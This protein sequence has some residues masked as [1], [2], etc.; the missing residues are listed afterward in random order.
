MVWIW[1]SHK[2]LW[3]RSSVPSGSTILE[4]SGRNLKSAVLMEEVSQSPESAYEGYL[5][6][7]P[8]LSLVALQSSCHHDVLLHHRL[9]VME[10]PWAKTSEIRSQSNPPF[11]SGYSGHVLCQ[12]TRRPD[13]SSSFLFWV[14]CRSQESTTM[15]L[16]S[17]CLCLCL[18]LPSFLSTY[19]LIHPSIYF[20]AHI[21]IMYSR[22]IW[23]LQCKPDWPPAAPV[24]WVLV[25]KGV[26]I[27]ATKILKY[28]KNI[29]LIHMCKY[30]SIKKIWRDTLKI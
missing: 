1:V 3:F 16:S 20:Q 30:M 21:L 27:P 12:G 7:G 18:S 5:V 28:W 11:P 13:N 9:K 25:I 4:T 26:T 29:Y 23:K 2:L 6:P 15:T 19:L 14:T 24:T 10:Q 17:V 8:L 22:L